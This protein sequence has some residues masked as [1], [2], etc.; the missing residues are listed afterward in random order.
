LRLWKKIEKQ[1]VGDV[2]AD[3]WKSYS[4]M[5]SAEKLR[6]GK[7]GTNMIESF[8]GQIKTLL[9]R[10]RRRTKCYSKCVNM[11]ILSLKLLMA[12]LNGT[13]SIQIY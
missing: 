7:R 3:Y 6:Q 1:A 12:K 4:E 2:H 8:N 13:L 5:I 11:M 10:F 9:A